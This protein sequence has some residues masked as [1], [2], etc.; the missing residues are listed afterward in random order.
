MKSFD[1]SNP[2][3]LIYGLLA[4]GIVLL[5]FALVRL[6]R[7]P[8]DPYRNVGRGYAPQGPHAAPP[9]RVMSMPSSVHPGHHPGYGHGPQAAPRSVLARCWRISTSTGTAARAAATCRIPMAAAMAT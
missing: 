5:L 1:W 3:L 2:K 9:P 7:G 4:V 8:R 6:V